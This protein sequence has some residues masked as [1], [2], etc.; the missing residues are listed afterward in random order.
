VNYKEG[1]EVIEPPF[2]KV[3]SLAAWTNAMIIAEDA[4]RVLIEQGVRPQIA[5]GVL[6]N[7]LKTEIMVTFNLREWRHFFKLRCAPTAHPQMRE[8]ANLILN[9][10]REYIPLIFEDIS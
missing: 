3:D 1:I 8:V 7:S 2:D 9:E 4:Y 6:P 10:M 5:R